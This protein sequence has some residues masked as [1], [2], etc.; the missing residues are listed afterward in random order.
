MLLRSAHKKLQLVV[1]LT[2]Q[3]LSDHGYIFVRFGLVGTSGV[4][5][6]YALLYLLADIGD[7]NHLLAASVATEAAILSN[8][9]F[10]NLWTFRYTR[11][12]TSW[13]RRA[14]QYNLFCLGGLVISV[15]VLA[16][17]TY[18]VNIHYLVA[19][20]FA[21]GAATLW[22]YGANRYWTWPI[23]TLDEDTKAVIEGGVE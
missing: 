19:N 2:L 22:N 20:I 6:N 3:V 8:F 18:L 9:T 13:R 21:I 12:K 5:V 23:E 10:N 16:V 14:L 7:L 4:A 1:G 17:L 15:L 11:P